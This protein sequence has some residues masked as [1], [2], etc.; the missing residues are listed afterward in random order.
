MNFGESPNFLDMACLAKTRNSQFFGHGL[1]CLIFSW[2]FPDFWKILRPAYLK[3]FFQN[4]SDK[5][6][7]IKRLLKKFAPY[8]S[9]E[10]TSSFKWTFPL[11]KALALNERTKESFN[12]SEEMQ[13]MCFTHRFWRKFLQRKNMKFS[14]RKLRLATATKNVFRLLNWRIFGL[15]WTVV[16]Y[17]ILIFTCRMLGPIQKVRSFWGSFWSASDQPRYRKWT[18][19]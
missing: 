19:R 18:S 5:R 13:N 9:R 16:K 17:G 10:K 2:F 15:P 4:G 6:K 14:I 1:F 8:T 3:S 7:W 12:Q 11:L